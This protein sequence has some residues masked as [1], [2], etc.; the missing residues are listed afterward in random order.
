[1]TTI[2]I[3]GA[4]QAGST[5][6][7]ASIAAGYDIVIANSRGPESLAGLISELGPRARAAHAAEAA[8]AAD[9][10]V[11]AFPY[12]P[13]A[14]LP[15]EELRGKVVI[16][17]NNYMVWR[18]GHIPEVDLGRT[19]IHQ[20]RQE[21][22]PAS[23][24]VKAFS[25]VQFHARHPIRVPGDRLPALVRLARPAGAPDRT[26]LVVSS[27]FPDAV[28]LVTRLYDDLGFDA[29]DNSPLSESWR[30]AP[31]TPMWRHHVDGQSREELI[32]NLGRADRVIS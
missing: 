27:D 16:D 28:E 14:R 20:L 15:V 23:K 2:G 6:A 22:L 11:T 10:A 8:A 26:A 3:L 24:V 31:G 30:S 18:D 19:T 21:Q 4:G 32:R 7:R 13:T 17:N 5:L 9:F 29:V 25:H 12:T 1:M